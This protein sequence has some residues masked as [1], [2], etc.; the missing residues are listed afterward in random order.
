[1]PLARKPAQIVVHLVGVTILQ[2]LRSV[3]PHETKIG[4]NGGADIGKLLK[5]GHC[6]MTDTGLPYH[7][8]SLYRKGYH[9]AINPPL[10]TYITPLTASRR[11]SLAGEGERILAMVEIN[12]TGNAYAKPR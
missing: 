8:I 9:V 4:R 11:V 5:F 2:I 3:D 10:P 1:M 12:L 7:R 6:G